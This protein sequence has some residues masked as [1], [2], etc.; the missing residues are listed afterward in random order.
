MKRL[1][2]AVIILC[3]T[4]LS[5][6][7]GIFRFNPGSDDNIYFKDDFSRKTSGWDKID[8]GAFTTNYTDGVYRIVIHESF[9]D[10]W[11]LQELLIEEVIIDVDATKAGGPDDNNFGVICRANEGSNGF[12]FFIIS[13]D[14]Y[15]GIGK[16]VD[17][18]QMLLGEEVMQPSEHVRQGYTTNH[19]QARCEGDQLTL[20]VNDEKLIEVQDDEFSIGGVGLIAGAFGSPG[21]DIIFDNFIA[22]RP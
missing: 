2:Y 14:G 8:D 5:C 15:F 3:L 18:I 10:V 7:S 6:S 19:I 22:S 1:V 20:L 11:S 12:Y 4:S 16:V 9:I 17:G 21:V 13:S